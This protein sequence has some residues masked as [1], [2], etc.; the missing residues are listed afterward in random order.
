MTTPILNVVWSTGRD[1]LCH[2][3]LEEHPGLLASMAGQS[4]GHWIGMHGPE[5][6]DTLA[7]AIEHDLVNGI[8]FRR[9]CL[10]TCADRQARHVVI[11]GLPLQPGCPAAFTG[12]IVDITEQKRALEQATGTARIHRLI[13]DNS[14]DLIAYCDMDG[15]YVHLSPSYTRIMGWPAEQMT[16]RPVVDFL[17][18]DDREPARE[19]LRQVLSSTGTPVVSEV[20]KRDIGGAFVSLSAKCCPVID[21]TSGKHMGAVLISRDITAEKDM[22]GKLERMAVEKLA[23]LESINDG[24]FSVDVDWNITYAN[25]RAADFAG[26]DREDAV[27]KSV[28]AVAPELWDS[29]IGGHL[30]KA[31]ASGRGM[32]FEEFYEPR[33]VWLN[34]RIYA[35]EEG[36]SVF[37]HDVTE[38]K[39]TEQALYLSNER[40]KGA[41]EAVEGVM[42][43][44]DSQGTF[45]E[46]QPQWEALTGQSFE[47]Y[48]GHGWADVI[49]PEDKDE[50]FRKAN[51]SFT[52]LIPFENAEHRLKCADGT[53]RLF[54]VKATQVRNQDG[55]VRE[56]V[57]VHTDITERREYESRIKYLANHD[58]LTG[59]PNRLLFGERLTHLLRQRGD[60]R[61]AVLFMDLNRFKIINDSLGHDIGDRL[62]V[63]IATRLRSGLRAGDTVARFGGDEFV[64]LF[65][66]VSSEGDVR[67]LARKALAIVAEPVKV[68]GHELRVTGSMG[69]S[70]YPEDGMTS[71]ALLKHADQAMYEAKAAGENNI[72]FSSDRF[73][74]AIGH[75]AHGAMPLACRSSS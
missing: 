32:S 55:S 38:R 19:A 66:A 59:L 33:G 51:A 35:H 44:A 15:R 54:S 36:L 11:T 45:L 22:R 28:W 9:E 23:L 24:F 49:H 17:H 14:D 64:F 68:A 63:E 65:E 20:R 69:V 67:L 41:I 39:R 6:R 29:T 1:G 16:G 27:G 3:F 70:L 12:A 58:A 7:R 34:E 40:F 8:A 10:V 60:R 43:N 13:V 2:L 47:Q 21:S 31:M 50:F 52:N 48:K 25:K 18:P 42:W 62:L 53:W 75:G 74:P 57:G 26:I 71:V 4:P 61:H 72:R 56:L 30:R 73:T 46:P 37:F 5:D